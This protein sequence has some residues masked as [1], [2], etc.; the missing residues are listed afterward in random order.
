MTPAIER[1]PER[2]VDRYAIF[3][4]IAAGGMATV[5]LGRLLGSAGFSRVVAAK[6][7]HRH[8]LRDPDFKRMFLAEARLAARIRHPNVVPIVDVLSHED[9]LIIVM[10]YVHGE[11]LLALLRAARKGHKSIPIPIACAIVAGML[12]GL[13]AAHEAQNERGEP[14]GIVHRD[15]SPQ[16]VLVGVDGVARV[17]DFGI[18]KAVHEQNQTNPGTLKGKFSYMAPEVVTGAAITRQADVFSAGIV[19]WEV[20]AGRMLFGGHT[21]HQS[22]L[23]IVQGG[24]PSPRQHNPAI[25][26][27]LEEV[28]TRALKID[29]ADRY[30]TALEL[31]V[32]LERVVPL[33]P[34]R[35]VGAWVRQ[36]AAG[37]LEKR[38][39]LIHDIE[40][41]SAVPQTHLTEFASARTPP[42]VSPQEIGL[43]TSLQ[44]APAELSSEIETLPL[45]LPEPNLT[46]MAPGVSRASMASW[47]DH[48]DSAADDQSDSY[49]LIV[50][51]GRQ[52]SQPHANTVRRQR[53]LRRAAGA[54]AVL[55]V[56]ALM[57]M[58]LIL[59]K[60]P[61]VPPRP[62]PPP[63]MDLRAAPPAA[64]PVVI[65]M[66]S[67]L[68]EPVAQVVPA[69][70]TLP[71]APAAAEV[72]APEPV[73]KHPKPHSP[74]RPSQHTH[75]PAGAS[76]ARQYLPNSL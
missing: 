6:R 60:T 7:M 27:A 18:A 52:G 55:G 22:L 48:S 5:H 73:P 53:L 19:L 51:D 12:E 1:K 9:E 21:E 71:E 32:D 47:D 24:Y 75:R 3:D 70:T 34:R 46:P 13:H 10:E 39:S 56:V 20:L 2:Q 31:A 26:P 44:P 67:P 11:S 30:A 76:H 57:S 59:R 50:L 65:P 41:S 40:T 8:F 66:P 42:P 25:A 49:A 62:P 38:E 68:D 69:T 16:N 64:R 15:V 14:L 37:T 61:S 29:I 23:R 17:L 28:V 43:G 54:T 63:S 58:L 35:V 33:A 74:P 72:I 36:W 45:P 4:E